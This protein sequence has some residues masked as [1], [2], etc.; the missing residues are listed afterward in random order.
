ME[1]KNK[2]LQEKGYFKLEEVSTITCEANME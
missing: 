2:T 1:N